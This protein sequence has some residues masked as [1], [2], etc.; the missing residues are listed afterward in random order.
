MRRPER[1]LDPPAQ[2][3]VE[4]ASSLG[5]DGLSVGGQ[6]KYNVTEQHLDDYNVGIE[7]SQTGYTA[8][9]KTEDHADRVVFSYVHSVSSALDVGANFLYNIATGL[10]TYTLGTGYRVDAATVVKAKTSSD[11]NLE[12]VYEQR[13]DRPGLTFAFSSKFNLLSKSTVPT[14]FGVLAQFGDE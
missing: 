4:G 10:R 5:Y 1:S 7:Y 13:L 14:E 8:T 2:T 3:V 12:T 9:V 6:V 11:G